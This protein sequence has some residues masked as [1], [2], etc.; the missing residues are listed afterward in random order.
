MVYS[1]DQD[2]EGISIPNEVHPL[3][4][5]AHTHKT[6][7]KTPYRNHIIALFAFLLLTEASNDIQ[8]APMTVIMESI[9]CKNYYGDTNTINSTT[10]LDLADFSSS[11]AAADDRR[12]KIEPIQ[13]ELANV[14]G[15][16][17]LFECLASI[18]VAVPFGF[19]ANRCGR[20][21][22]LALAMFGLTLARVWIQVVCWWPE[23]LPLRISW[24]SAFFHLIGGGNL[25][26]GSLIYTI[27][28]DLTLPEHRAS[29]F[30]FMNAAV[31][32]AEMLVMPL[33]A[34]LMR[35]NPWIPVNIGLATVALGSLI[36]ISI[37]PETVHLQETE[38]EDTEEERHSL[39][40]GEDSGLFSGAK[41]A[42]HSSK[43]LFRLI[44]VSRE[45]V[46]LMIASTMTNM[47]RSSTP[48]FIQYV[49]KKFDWD[50]SEASLLTS[51]RAALNLILSLVLLP[52][53]SHLFR[54]RLNMATEV[55]DLWLTRFSASVLCLG[56]ALMALAPNLFFLVSGLTIFAHGY[57]LSALIHSL[58][59][60]V[61]EP[62]HIVILYNAMSVAETTGDFISG[63]ILSSTFSLGQRIGK[64]WFGL[65]MMVMAFFY[66]V[67]TVA[68]F[69]I[70]ARW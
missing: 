64:E 22:V 47:D 16:Q 5:E 7:A 40:E 53:A 10:T 19:A 55:K 33:A 3:L 45:T 34:T 2:A 63:P 24:L 18:L 41:R 42:L 25:V 17:Q 62:Q 28:T 37:L 23:V 54:T 49:S 50:I 44:S 38:S 21:V 35:T 66:L 1:T 58:A 52:L 13:S 36:T 6:T 26:V 27:M 59:A 20:K 31:L 67:A 61:V 46:A 15:W 8:I 39:S 60:S 56:S 51:Y 65:F 12:C 11:W 32:I 70:R 29:I 48:Y 4:P 43:D 30:L 57:G 9:I 68:I 14:R 69:S